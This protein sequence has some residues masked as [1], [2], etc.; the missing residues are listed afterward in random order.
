VIFQPQLTKCFCPTWGNSKQEIR[1][2]I[3]AATFYAVQLKMTASALH[4]FWSNW[5]IAI[6]TARSELHKVLFWPCLCF[7]VCMKYIW[8]RWTDLC[9]IHR[10]TSLVPRSDE[11]ECQGQG[12]QGQKNRFSA[13]I[14]YPV[15]T[16]QPVVK[17]VVQPFDNWLYRVNKHPAGCQTGLTTGW[18]FVYTIQPVVKSVWQQVVSCK[19]GFRNRWTDIP[20]IH[21]EDVWCLARTS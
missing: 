2:L 6:F 13:D 4:H 11:F 21:M 7:F 8:N 12:H 1:K 16:M 19:R 14:W 10:K 20:Q 5:R 18:M 3:W 15:Y 9:Q 17:P